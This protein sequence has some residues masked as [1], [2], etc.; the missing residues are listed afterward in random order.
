[1]IRL[2]VLTVLKLVS[3]VPARPGSVVVCWSASRVRQLLL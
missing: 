1:M 2:S 3:G